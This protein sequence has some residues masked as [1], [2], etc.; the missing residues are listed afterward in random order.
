MNDLDLCLDVIQGYVNVNH[1]GVNSSKTTGAGDFKFG[2]QLC[3]GMTRRCTYNFPW[4]W[5]WPSITFSSMG[6]VTLGKP[7]FRCVHK[8]RPAGQTLGDEWRL[9]GAVVCMIT[10]SATVISAQFNISPHNLFMIQNPITVS[11]CLTIAGVTSK[12]TALDHTGRHR[13]TLDRTGPYQSKNDWLFR[14]DDCYE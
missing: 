10:K 2:T 14:F 7:C 1:C 8:C 11:L 13:T 4:K 6:N 3:I 5:A 12:L 9:T